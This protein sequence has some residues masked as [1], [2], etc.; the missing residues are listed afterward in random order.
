MGGDPLVAS[1]HTLKSLTEQLA[2]IPHVKRLR[3]HSRMPIVLPERITFEFIQAVTT[4]ALN[5]V[6]VT[7]CNHPQEINQEVKKAMH[8]L[9]QAKITLLNQAVLLKGG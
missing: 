7:H 3:I 8:L 9:T 1:D 4:P 5:T 2:K 6:L